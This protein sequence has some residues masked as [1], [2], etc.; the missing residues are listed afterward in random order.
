LSV[1]DA[2]AMLAPSI[3]LPNAKAKKSVPKMK[4]KQ[5]NAPKPADRMRVIFRPNRSD[6]YPEGTSKIIVE[7]S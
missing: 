1:P 4:K 6:I 5:Q 3:R 2:N 7:I